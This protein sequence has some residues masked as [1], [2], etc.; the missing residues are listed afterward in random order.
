VE[1][2]GGAFPSCVASKNEK[3]YEMLFSDLPSPLADS[4]LVEKVSYWEN[5]LLLQS[6]DERQLCLSIDN[7]KSQPL[8]LQNEVSDCL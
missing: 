4:V 5:G 3:H 1:N 6:V 7:H 8:K 2:P